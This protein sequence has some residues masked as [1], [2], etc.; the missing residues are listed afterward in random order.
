MFQRSLF[1]SGLSSHLAD[2]CAGKFK[3]GEGR[4]STHTGTVGLC[5]GIVESYVLEGPGWR[6]GCRLEGLHT[7]GDSCAR[8]EFADYQRAAGSVMTT[9]SLPTPL[10]CFRF[11][12]FSYIFSFLSFPFHTKEKRHQ[13]IKTSI[14]CPLI[15][16]VIFFILC[17]LK[18][19]CR[20]T[21]YLGCIDPMLFFQLP[22][23]LNNANATV[24]CFV[25]L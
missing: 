21:V 22:Q 8:S 13:K 12:V 7:G 1:T 24:F 9:P 16:L 25:L 17:S 20:N 2:R 4:V 19:S 18:I 15:I 14:K 5:G 11:L 3:K 10:V 6:W 23:D